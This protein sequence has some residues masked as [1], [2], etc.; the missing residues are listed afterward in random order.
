LCQTTH[1]RRI[2]VWNK[3]SLGYLPV[4]VPPVVP[5]HG[6]NVGENAMGNSSSLSRDDHSVET[7]NRL[8]PLRMSTRDLRPGPKRDAVLLATTDLYRDNVY[9][10]AGK[11]LGEIEELVLDI[12]SGH[13]A[14]AL[15][16]VGGFLGMGQK[17]IA[18]PWSTVTIDRVYQRCVVNID[19]ARLMEAPSLE[20]DPLPR[21]ADPRWAKQVHAYFDC[22]PFWE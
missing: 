8:P 13:V 18:I 2:E 16:A 1:R 20:G 15:M 10:L 22:K 3:F 11:F 5:T 6:F 7:L 14:Y 21:M 4:Y 12:H 19:L 17:M 9:D